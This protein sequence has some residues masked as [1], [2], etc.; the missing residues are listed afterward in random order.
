MIF[1]LTPNPSIDR[2]F[3]LSGLEIREVNRATNMRI[4]AGGKGINISRALRAHAFHA[5][6]VF[7]AGG[8]DGVLLTELLAQD[9][10]ES[11]PV[12]VGGETRTN[13][14]LNHGGEGSN[15]S[16]TKVNAPG[17]DISAR[18]AESLIAALTSRVK[19]GD[20]VVGAGSLPVG[21][22][23]DYYADVARS[24]ADLGASF[25][26]DTSGPALTAA[27]D[28]ARPGTIT[29][30]KPN[31][32]EL[33]ELVGQPL[34]T[35][36]DAVGAA[37][38]ICEKGVGA[39]LVSLGENGLLFVGQSPDSVMWAGGTKLDAV[40][41][42]GAGDVTLAGFLAC[43]GTTQ[44]KLTWAAAWGRAAVMLPGTAVPGP[45][46]INLEDVRLVNDPDGALNLAD[47]R[48]TAA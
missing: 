29:L 41:T 2:A 28:R 15:A 34:H 40:S 46:N 42:V 30:I 27:L 21:L 33:T 25:Y 13:I 32:E 22:A 20:V 8:S 39:V 48:T 47:L 19:P 16:T 5:P 24:V 26:L 35:V 10:I 38:T 36:D 7:P 17:P 11:V 45:E 6:A 12:S 9:G 44:E 3:V 14:T 1:T 18:E 4:D 31:V 23:A 37:Q 43:S